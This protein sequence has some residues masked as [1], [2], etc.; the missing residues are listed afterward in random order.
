MSNE[1][2]VSQEFGHRFG[3]APSYLV[4]APGRVNLIGEHTGYNEGF[5]MPL[6]IDRAIRLALRP[7]SD[8]QVIVH[9]LDFAQT[10]AFEIGSVAAITQQNPEPDVHA[11]DERYDKCDEAGMPSRVRRY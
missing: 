11:R 6:A 4:R 10:L 9:S 2:R 1:Q 3:T 5:V 8:G 7:R